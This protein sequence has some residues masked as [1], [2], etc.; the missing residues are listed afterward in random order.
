M[1]IQNLVKELEEKD[2]FKKFMEDNPDAYL[3]ACFAVIGDEEKCQIDYFIPSKE[4]MA[5]VAYPFSEMKIYE[6]KIKNCKKMGEIKLDISDL[7]DRVEE[8]K[9]ENTIGDKTS[10]I[11]AILKDDIWSLT[12]LFL[13][14]TMLKIKVDALTGNVIDFKKASMFDFIKKVD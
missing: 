13:S 10:K 9:K 5:S 7:W 6:D 3:G 1:K 14:M 12:V 11:I 2:F 8:I 4:K